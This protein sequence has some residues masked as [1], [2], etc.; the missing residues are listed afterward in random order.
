[1]VEKKNQSTT[2]WDFMRKIAIRNYFHSLSKKG[3]KIESSEKIA[4]MLF[5][6]R[7]AVHSG[8]LIRIWD[9]YFV[10]YGVLPVQ[11]KGKFIKKQSLIHDED[12]QRIL[13]AFISSESQIALVST[14]LVQCVP[15]NFH[16]RL[17]LKSAVSISQRTAQ[18]WLNILSLRFERF[19][20]GLYN[21]GYERADVVSYR[22]AFLQRMS[23]Y[24]QRMVQY[25]GDFMKQ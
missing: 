5:P 14:K 13:R 25:V 2:K 17:G 15:E 18:R 4:L 12:V 9:E 11:S 21:D 8:R 1:M 24:E 19:V 22:H 3:P 23:S 16:L 10:N 7:N 6:D 20:K